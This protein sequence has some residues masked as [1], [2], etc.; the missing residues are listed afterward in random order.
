MKG[1]IEELLDAL[2]LEL[3]HLIEQQ[4][5]CRVNIERLSM[6]WKERRIWKIFR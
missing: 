1:K 5:Q 3:L 6:R 4:T 2:Y